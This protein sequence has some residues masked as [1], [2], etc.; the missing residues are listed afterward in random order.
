LTKARSLRSIEIVKVLKE[1][2][3]DIEKTS[4]SHIDR[5]IFEEEKLLELAKTGI[6]L[7][8]D[9]FGT[10]VSHYQVRVFVFH[11]HCRSFG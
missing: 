7:E 8:Y 9:L 10:E 11:R 5:T 6:Y 2:G 1:A 4:M 3:A